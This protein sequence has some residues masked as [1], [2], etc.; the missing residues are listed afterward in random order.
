MG[1][2]VGDNVSIYSPRT[3]RKIR[4]SQK[5]GKDVEVQTEEYVV[6]GITSWIKGWKAK[7]WLTKS[8]EPVKNREL[9][10]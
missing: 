10:R 1:L 8:R 9:V 6:K 2:A 5:Q 3:A 4:R 7:G